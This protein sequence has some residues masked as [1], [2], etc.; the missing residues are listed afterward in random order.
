MSIYA[1][2][3]LL[4]GEAHIRLLRILPG[5]PTCQI[6]CEF[7]TFDI[8]KAP[9]YK[10][11]SYECGSKTH[12]K[13]IDVIG[14]Q[15]TIRLNLWNFLSR[16]RSHAYYDY[17]WCDAICIEPGNDRE[18]NHQVQLMS[19][20][21]RKANVVLVW[22]GERSQNS[23]GTLSAIHM[24]STCMNSSSRL[25]Y[26]A[27]REKVW[28]GLVELSQ[29]RYWTRIWI[30]QEITVA[31]E[32][33][34][35]CGDE[36]V[37]WRAFATACK[38]PPDQ[39]TQWA[40]ELWAPL[41]GANGG[42]KMARS[43]AGRELYHS[44]M[45]QLMRS[46]RRWPSYVDTFKTLSERYEYS[47]CEDIRERVFA[48][49]SVSREVVLKRGITVDY[50]K[51]TEETFFSLIAWGGSGPISVY[52]RIKFALL[53]AKVMELNWLE[54]SLE[55]HIESDAQRSPS[56]WKW[57]GQTLPMAVGCQYLGKWTFEPYSNKIHSA[58]D[59]GLFRGEPKHAFLPLNPIEHTD[60]DFDLFGFRTSGVFLACKPTGRHTWTV[61]TRAY[62]QFYGN[63]ADRNFVPSIFNGLNVA[64][65]VSGG[66][67]LELKNLAQFMEIFLDTLDPWVWADPE[68]SRPPIAGAGSLAKRPSK[69]DRG[70]GEVI[71][72]LKITSSLK[73]TE[74]DDA[75]TEDERDEG[76][77]FEADWNNLLAESE[78]LARPRVSRPPI[79]KPR[80]Q[81]S[82]VLA[83]ISEKKKISDPFC[84]RAPIIEELEGSSISTTPLFLPG[85]SLATSMPANEPM[86]MTQNFPSVPLANF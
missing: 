69:D 27:G 25:P 5:P 82:S 23:S 15:T 60:L 1:N 71:R 9:T 78:V 46:Q 17:L 40:S 50:Q 65:V 84:E 11:L 34:L 64:A 4:Q 6:K 77:S 38:F 80:R 73:L 45:Y 85:I 61:I 35:F 86:Y 72:N 39:L 30:V 62:I 51:N 7:K 53:A 58:I 22:L 68:N 47:G 70:L 32:L 29:R 54:Y 59:P 3:P 79:D 18:R 48:L 44:T 75:E 36:K 52:S 10:A 20:I 19:Q 66:H 33:E 12:L 14:Q 81:R 13:L 56:F 2:F 28:D 55:C 76:E 83:R 42:Q 74:N 26:L 41:T 57:M 63:L 21:Y 43:A 16:L 67:I 37:A 31:R 49:L 24:I 8:N